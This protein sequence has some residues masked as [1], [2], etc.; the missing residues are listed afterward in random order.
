MKLERAMIL[1][2]SQ[3]NGI[4][5]PGGVSTEPRLDPQ[6]VQEELLAREVILGRD[7]SELDFTLAW[8]HVLRDLL[9]QRGLTVLGKERDC[10]T[11]RVVGT[12]ADNNRITLDE[13]LA[14]PRAEHIR[15]MLVVANAFPTVGI[16]PE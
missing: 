16:E 3:W 5:E 1:S 9:A 2:T 11:Y 13:G 12:N 8:D 10:Q 7:S 14:K 6:C 4:M 15:R